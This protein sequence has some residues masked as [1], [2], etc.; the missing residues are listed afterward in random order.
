M[1]LSRFDQLPKIQ[2]SKA[3][4][5]LYTGKQITCAFSGNDIVV[6]QAYNEQIANYAA[7][8]QTFEGCPQF[9]MKRMTWIKPNFL[10]MMHRADW[11]TK[12]INQARILALFVNKDD[13]EREILKNGILTS[14]PFSSEFFDPNWTH[15]SS[16]EEWM[17]EVADTKNSSDRIRVQWDPYHPPSGEKMGNTRAIQLGLKGV[18]VKS[19]LNCVTKIEDITDFVKEQNELR[20][21]G[22]DV[23][24]PLET[25]YSVQDESIAKK[26]SV[27]KSQE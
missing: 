24:I 25:V 2:W 1:S 26:L 10:W 9:N 27:Q 17:K 6:Y 16:R 3:Q 19:L 20:L 8:N 5:T 21:A 14:D 22:E 23:L 11:A 18:F 7:Q 12:D 15:Y 4:Q 13:F